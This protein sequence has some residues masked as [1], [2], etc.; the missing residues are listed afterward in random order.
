M[1]REGLL[2]TAAQRLRASRGG[3]RPRDVT[4]DVDPLPIEVHGHQPGSAYNGHYHARVY[5]HPLVASLAETGDLLDVRLHEG[6]AHTAAGALAF[7]APL[8]DRVEQTLCQVASVRLDAGFP[9]EA[10]LAALEARGTP[11]VARVKNNAVLDRLAAPYLRRPVGRPPAEPRVWCHEL[12]YQARSW[13]RPRRVVPVVL[14]RPGELFLHHVWLIT[15]W[16]EARM[17]GEDL[18]DLYRDRGTAEGHFGELMSVLDPA[19]SS[20]PRPKRHYRGAVPARAARPRA[21]SSPRTR[22]SC[23]STRS[24][25]TW[26]MPCASSSRRPPARAGASCG[27][28]SASCAS[29]RACCSTAGAQSW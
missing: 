2:E 16:T 5:H 18:L 25:I 21:M 19:L 20:S 12:T 6:T 29:R 23:C 14:K 15:N 22:S 8:L 10:L 28:A 24:P 9:E 13:S 7:L 17:R 27:C 4:V 11:Y 3:H 26:C 1:L